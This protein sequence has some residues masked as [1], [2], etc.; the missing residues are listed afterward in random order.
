MQSPIFVAHPGRDWKTMCVRQVFSR[1][2][3]V[4]ILNAAWFPEN[5]RQ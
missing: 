2:R 3:K 1:G 4:G 5:G